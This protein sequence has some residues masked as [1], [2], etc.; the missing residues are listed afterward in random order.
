MKRFS[1]IFMILFFISILT[2]CTKVKLEENQS[3]ATFKS[4]GDV[5]LSEYLSDNDAD[6]YLDIDTSDKNSKI[7]K[8]LISFFD[9]NLNMD[10]KVT[11]IKATKDYIKFTITSKDA[12]NMGFDA[13]YAL[14][15][16]AD[17]YY[18]DDVDVLAENQDFV[19]F[20]NGNDV[21]DKDLSDYEDD[22]AVQVNG[23]EEGTYYKFPGKILVL[24]DLDF[25]KI[26]N[27][28]IYI[29]DDENGIVVYNK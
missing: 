3:F 21:K 18:G 7:K 10:V 2:G 11:K 13:D 1:V 16:Y 6:D 23:G 15:D 4:N 26:S 25:N 29:D 24:N 12:D 20:K 9:D 14:S 19:Y 22:I 28:T 8:D 17:D 5:I 27:D